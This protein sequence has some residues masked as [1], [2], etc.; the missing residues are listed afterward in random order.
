MEDIQ[1]KKF[2]RKADKHLNGKIEAEHGKRNNHK[3]KPYFVLQY[4]LKN[5]DENHTKSAYDIMG[6]LEENGIVAERR[7][8]YRDIEEINKANL[9]IQEDYTVDEAEEILAE[10]EYDEEKLIV[11]DKSKKGFYVK[12]R[13]FDLNDIRLL[14]ECIYSSKFIAEGQAK[15]LV[16]VVCD[17]VSDYQAEKIRH[18]AF[19]TDRVKTN[20]KGVLNN[21][22]TINEAMST[23]IDGLPHTPEKICFKYLKYSISDMKQQVERRQGEKY[24]VSPFALVINDGNYY[25]LAFDDKSQ[26]LRTY[27]VDRMKGVDPYGEPRDGEEVFKEIDLKSYTQRVFSMYGGEEKRITLK[28]ITPLLDAVVDRFGTKDV[29]YAKSDERHFT[30]TAKVEI[31][32]QFFGWLLGFGKRVQIVSPPEVREEFAVY[33]DKIREMY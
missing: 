19:L 14:A 29:H 13:H 18:N 21:I 5:S 31:S 10:D 6:F 30:I 24:V 11:Y 27:R 22:A 23:K 1:Y 2:Y 26:K 28:F 17:F 25:L 7:S 20:N 33:L 12:Q 4:L 32:N 15:R 8:V 9:I 3:M 16:D